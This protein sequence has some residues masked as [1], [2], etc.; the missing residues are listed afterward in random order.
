MPSTYFVV[1]ATVADPARRKAFDEWYR[2]EHMPDAAKAFGV[3]KAWRRVPARFLSSRKSSRLVEG[4]SS[5][6][7]KPDP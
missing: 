6:R 1:R 4:L 5:S 7:R 3:K 2:R